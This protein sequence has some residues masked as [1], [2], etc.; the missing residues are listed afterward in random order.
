MSTQKEKTHK[1]GDMKR[2]L[3]LVSK[4]FALRNDMREKNTQER[5]R[6]KIR[7]YY[8]LQNELID[9]ILAVDGGDKKLVK[10]LLNINK[11]RLRKV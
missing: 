7:A 5:F 10:E 1:D 11:Y 6:C 3:I 4:R 9:F 2:K 8:D